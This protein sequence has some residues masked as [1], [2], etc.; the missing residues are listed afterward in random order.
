MRNPVHDIC[1]DSLHEFPHNAVNNVVSTL[2]EGWVRQ[3][4]S[5]FNLGRTPHDVESDGGGRDVQRNFKEE[6]NRGF[7]VGKPWKFWSVVQGSKGWQP[8]VEKGKGRAGTSVPTSRSV[9]ILDSRKVGK[10][11]T[12]CLTLTISLS[13]FFNS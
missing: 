7:G 10:L 1:C 13:R 9:R 4:G 2:D 6:V 3:S 12:G 8:R 5:C 11:S